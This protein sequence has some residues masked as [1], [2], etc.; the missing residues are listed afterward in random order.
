MGKLILTAAQQE[1][2]GLAPGTYTVTVEGRD[3]Q[4]LA[5]RATRNKSGSAKLGPVRVKIKAAPDQFKVIYAPDARCLE[6]RPDVKAARF[7]IKAYSYEAARSEAWRNL[8][9]LYG[10]G[11]PGWNSN[12][13]VLKR[14]DDDVYRT[15]TG[16]SL[17][18][19]EEHL[20]AFHTP[21]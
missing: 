15:E 13:H 14:C 7:E 2:L 21:T 12:L 3:V 1:A 10:G 5:W 8:K 4:H 16:Q 20:E 11:V 19:I 17:K 18:E 6:E 9:R